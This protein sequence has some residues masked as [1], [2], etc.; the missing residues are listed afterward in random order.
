MSAAYVKTMSLDRG[1][2]LSLTSSADQPG[3]DCLTVITFQTC[4]KTLLKICE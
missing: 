2:I 3:K 4:L 1:G